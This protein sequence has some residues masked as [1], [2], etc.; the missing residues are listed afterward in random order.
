MRLGKKG[1]TFVLVLVSLLT[2]LNAS[3]VFAAAI[4]YGSEAKGYMVSSQQLREKVATYDDSAL[5][6]TYKSYADA[7]AKVWNNT[8]VVTFKRSINSQNKIEMMTKGKGNTDAFA[9]CR[10]KRVNAVNGKILAFDIYYNGTKMN[11]R[12]DKEN[13]STAAHELGHALGL[14]DL[15]NAYNREQIMCGYGNRRTATKPSAKDI[16]GAKYATR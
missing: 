9:T 8:G 1:K 6:A 4:V 11:I 7:G 16:K 13:K 14:Q 3:F 10:R 12:S 2:V 15:Y 5:D